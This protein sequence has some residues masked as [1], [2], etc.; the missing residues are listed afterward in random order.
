MAME[1]GEEKST[2][3]PAHRF[4]TKEY[5]LPWNEAIIEDCIR[6]GVA[7]SKSPLEVLPI[8]QVMDR[9]HLFHSFPVCRN[10]KSHSPVLLLRQESAGGN[11]QDFVRDGGFRNVYLGTP[12]Y[13]PIALLLHHMDIHIRIFLFAG[14]LHP[15]PFDV[16]LGT[17]ADQILFLKSLQPFHKV[18]MVLSGSFVLLIGLIRD[19]I[20]GIGRI[21]SHAPLNATSGHLTK[22]SRPLL[23]LVAILLTVVDMTE[24]IDLLPRQ[25]RFGCTQVF[26]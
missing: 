7:R 24:S 5:P 21:D 20:D 26:I 18:L 8:T 9:H 1:E 16:R 15:V 22:G 19:I 10:G 25:M 23:L 13:D 11:D 12:D 14:S 17:T 4:S 6:V 3:P 2:C